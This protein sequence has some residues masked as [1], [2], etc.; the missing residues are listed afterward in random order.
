MAALSPVNF[1][2]QIGGRGF[3]VGYRLL[4]LLFVIVLRSPAR[5]DQPTPRDEASP[6]A[7]VVSLFV[8]DLV[9]APADHAAGFFISADGLIAT[10]HHVIANASRITAETKDGRDFSVLGIAADDPVHDLA[11]VRIS[12]TGYP[13][14][15]LGSFEEIQP[16]DPIRVICDQYGFQGNIR[17]GTVGK[18]ENLADD[19]RFLIINGPS[20]KGE[21][22]SPV[23]DAAGQVAG[24]I[25]CQ[26]GDAPKSLAVSVD[27]I[28]QELAYAQ[29]SGELLALTKQGK[30]TYDDLYDDP[31][32]E[33]ALKA[34]YFGDNAEALRRMKLVCDD[35][36]ESAAAHALLGSYY[37][38]L[39]LLKE[40]NEAFTEAIGIR[41]DYTFAQASLAMVLA[42]QG[43]PEKALIMV[44]KAG[45]L[46]AEQKSRFADTWYNVGGTLIVLGDYDAAGPIIR[47]LL[48]INTPEAKHSANQLS[49]ALETLTSP[50]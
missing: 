23:L 3:S 37:A 20:E 41:P 5:S 32:L 35:F 6:G 34:A 28:N 12:G 27:S 18:A 10:A 13:F 15:K 14:L 31:N 45:K 39:R 42:Y 2:A 36:P 22:G 21:S 1:V 9:G 7:A 48:D 25:R 47:I 46:A 49:K 4:F 43:E 24:L 8:H 40:S 11:L 16:G 44:K 33:P 30:R 19:Y 17:K 26:H 29:K 38:R 50:K